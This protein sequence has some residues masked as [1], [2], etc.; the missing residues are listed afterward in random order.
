MTLTLTTR[1]LLGPGPTNPYPEATVGLS[2]PLLGHLDPE[3]IR[4]MDETC[5][6]L[7]AVW[8]TESSR[9]LPLSATG[10]AGMEAAFVNTVGE[11]DVVV[12][13]VNGL[14]GERMCE[15]ARRCGAEVVRVDHEWGRPIDPERV[16]A[17]HPAPKVI[18]AVHAETSTGVRSDIAA[19]GQLK[20]DALLLV[21]AVTSIGGTELRAD[22]WGVDVAYAGSQKC[23]GTPPGLAPFTI[24]ERAFARRVET[25]RSWYLDLGLLGGYVGGA[26][27]G[28]RT[29]H[30]TAPTAMVLSLHGAL[31]RILD[32]GLPAV[33]ERHTRAGERLQQGLQEMGLELFAQE[34]YRL[35]QLTTVRVP[36]GVESAAVR[37][38]LLERY[39]IEIGAGVGPYADTVWRI[40]LMGPN[41]GDDTVALV[42]AALGDVLGR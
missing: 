7:R 5:D 1:Y 4:L 24:N 25:P 22:A 26:T 3:F 20:G 28:K 8:Q 6:M 41:A 18:A 13:A 14:F 29:Y 31:R 36:D 38:E 34:G 19:L 37:A 40:G 27:G 10:S 23:L 17:A 30:H 9:T 16:A 39:D 21:D 2:A 42:L 33:W 15:V 12:V 11:G 32:E 35:P